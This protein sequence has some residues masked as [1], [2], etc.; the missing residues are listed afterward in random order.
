[1][2]VVQNSGKV[3]LILEFLVDGLSLKIVPILV[4]LP[5]SMGVRINETGRY[6]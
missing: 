2:H 6:R 1:M 3:V 5:S 4:K